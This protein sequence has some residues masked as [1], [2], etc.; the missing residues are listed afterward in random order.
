MHCCCKEGVALAAHCCTLLQPD[1]V[2]ARC[3]LC[4]SITPSCFLLL[5]LNAL[6]LQYGTHYAGYV[7]NL[8]AGLTNAT[9][10]GVKV[11]AT[12]LTSKPHN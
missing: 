9:A 5:L 6:L 2:Q 7:R 12:D 10:A 1:D 8:N 3:S 11:A 4:G